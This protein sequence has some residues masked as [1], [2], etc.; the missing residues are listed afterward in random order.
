MERAA[1][2]DDLEWLVRL[3]FDAMEPHQQASGHVETR[4]EQRATVLEDFTEIRIIQLIVGA[5]QL[6]DVG[7]TKVL[8]HPDAWKLAQFQIERATRGHG[9][10]RLVLDHL[11]AQ[12]R[13]VGVPVELDV[14]EANPAVRL[15]ERAGFAKTG[16]TERGW[17]MRMDPADPSAGLRGGAWPPATR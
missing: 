15:Y 8:R 12:A 9:L 14:L 2:E 11:L 3:R 10:G 7:M 4:S 5:G 16:E 13:A 17:H 1:V 6:R